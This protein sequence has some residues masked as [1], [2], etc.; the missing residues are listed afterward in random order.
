MPWRAADSQCPLPVAS[1]AANTPGAP[2]CP[3][4]PTRTTAGSRPLPA[5]HARSG[6]TP[7]PTRMWSHASRRPSLRVRRSTRSVPAAAAT[8][9]PRMTS[10]PSLR[11]RSAN[12]V[13]TAGPSNAASG[14]SAASTIVVCT[15]A[16]AAAAATSWPMKPAPT[17]TRR[18]P[19]ASAARSARASSRVRSVWTLAKPSSSARRARAAAGGDE[20]LL[21]AEGVAVGERDDAPRAV[22][23]RGA[24]AE[25]QLDGVVAVPGR[26]AQAEAVLGL[27]ARE[28]GLGERRAVVGSVGLAAHHPHAA[29]IARR[30]AGSPRSAGRPARRP[31]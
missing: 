19:S 2:V 8:L 16:F 20:Q 25:E 29:L 14:A 15:P 4:A 22:E 30:G 28:D 13:P 7:M 6:S 12:Q 18:P 31:R 5:S 24:G 17:M 11:C 3:S 10:T 27:G 23:G 26:R 21:V 1:P 9:V